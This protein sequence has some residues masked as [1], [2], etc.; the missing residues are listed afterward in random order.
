MTQT[1]PTV[2][3]IMPVYEGE[4]FIAEALH[5][6]LA[7]H[8]PPDE[9]VVVDDGCTDRSIEVVH[10]VLQGMHREPDDAPNVRIIHRTNGGPAAARNTGIANTHHEL[11]AFH[12]AD[13]IALP[14]WLEGA[15]ARLAA[16]PTLSA[17]VG[18]QELLIEPGAR[19]PAWMDP[20]EDD[21]PHQGHHVMNMVVR[22]A[23]IDLVGPFD[24]SLRIA[25][26]TDLVLRM[27][28]AGLGVAFVDDVVVQRRIHNSSLTQDA[29]AFRRGQFEA[30]AR[31][32]RRKKVSQ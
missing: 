14:G 32:V 10:S 28:D 30:L 29:A 22:R 3:V 21:S 26:D 4:R 16:D 1:A 17:V 9:I 15:M 20:A 6:L 23:A 11:I 13:D 18:R 8:R 31:R 19:L 2:S 27:T 25:E 12:D 24:E 7:Q 5:S